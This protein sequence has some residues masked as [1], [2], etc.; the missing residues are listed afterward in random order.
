MTDDNWERDDE[1][2]WNAAAAKLEADGYTRQSDAYYPA[3]FVKD[4][5]KVV[6]TR[7]LATHDWQPR[8]L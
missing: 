8:A 1:K 2:A 3:V 7:P 6:L 4:G 5:D